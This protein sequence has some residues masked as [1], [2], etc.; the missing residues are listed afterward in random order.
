MQEA[1]PVF[2][3]Q[4]LRVLLR[5]LVNLDPYTFV[6]DLATDISQDPDNDQRSAEEICWQRSTAPPKTS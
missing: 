6:D 1:P 2:T 5:A 3:A 4:Q